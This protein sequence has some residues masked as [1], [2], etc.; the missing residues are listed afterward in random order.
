MK[1]KVMTERTPALKRVPP[2]DQ[3]IPVDKEGDEFTFTNLTDGINYIYKETKAKQY[4]LDAEAG[5]VYT[6]QEIENII[7]QIEQPEPEQKKY[8]IYGEREL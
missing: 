4:H 3:W 5:V 2:G 6:V 7:E 8:D 1:V